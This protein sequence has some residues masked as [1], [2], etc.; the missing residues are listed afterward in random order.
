MRVYCSIHCIVHIDFVCVF[1]V[2]ILQRFGLNCVFMTNNWMQPIN[3]GLWC[4][5]VCVEWTWLLHM[6]MRLHVIDTYHSGVHSMCLVR[7]FV[8]LFGRLNWSRRNHCKLI[9]HLVFFIYFFQ[10]TPCSFF[11]FTNVLQLE[12]NCRQHRWKV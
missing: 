8:D 5:C 9:V 1:S 3:I 10:L 6:H 4:V 11:V 12:E 7:V 2:W